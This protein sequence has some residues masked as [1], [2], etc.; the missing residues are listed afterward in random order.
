MAELFLSFPLFCF[1]FSAFLLLITVLGLAV[2]DRL[3]II[4]LVGIQCL[5]VSNLYF[6]D[7]KKMSSVLMFELEHIQLFFNTRTLNNIAIL[8]AFHVFLNIN[9]LTNRL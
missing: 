3:C 5:G 1:E 8:H 6:D 2:S 9:I 7:S 4:E